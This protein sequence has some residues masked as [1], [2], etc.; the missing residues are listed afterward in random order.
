MKNRLSSDSKSVTLKANSQPIDNQP[1]L[2]V[3]SHQQHLYRYI[4]FNYQQ[5]EHHIQQQDILTTYTQIHN[6]PE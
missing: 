5:Q 6:Q 4:L 3:F 1:S 2:L